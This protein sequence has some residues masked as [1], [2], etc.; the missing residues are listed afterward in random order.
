MNAVQGKIHSMFWQPHKTQI[1][2][3]KNIEFLNVKLAVRTVITRRS[4]WP[5]G[6]RRTSAAARLLRS[7][8]R[9]PPGAWKFVCCVCVVCCQVEVSATSWSLVQRNPT[10]CGASLCVILNPQEWG[11]HEPRWVAAPQQKRTHTHT[12]TH[13]YTVIT[14]LLSV[15]K[16]FVKVF[17]LPVLNGSFPRIIYKSNKNTNWFPTFAAM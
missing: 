15:Y 6:L 1:K 11:G 9:I 2:C 10:D 8:V 14:R 16:G 7:W 3:G 4:Q 5:R 12:H 13:T 17:G